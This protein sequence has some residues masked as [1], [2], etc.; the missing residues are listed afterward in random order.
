MMESRL[1]EIMEKR[2]MMQSHLARV[3]GANKSTINRLVKYGKIPELPLAYKIAK[4]L[5]LCIEDI[6]YE[7][8]D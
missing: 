8:T 6:W 7:R 1:K 4:E 3:T 5:D 2:G